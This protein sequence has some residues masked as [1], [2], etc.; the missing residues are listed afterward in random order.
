MTLL[1]FSDHPLLLV[2]VTLLSRPC[3]SRGGQNAKE[4][5]ADEEGEKPRW[6][7][8]DEEKINEEGSLWPEGRFL[9]Q[10][11]VRPPKT[12]AASHRTGC[13]PTLT[14]QLLPLECDAV[15]V[16]QSDQSQRAF[17][18]RCF[19]PLTANFMASAWLQ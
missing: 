16:D 13:G 10:D 14:C 18:T 6:R 15:K 12:M 5:G 19:C 3:A 7:R 8:F 4:A 9:I 17:D 2:V 1:S 11:D